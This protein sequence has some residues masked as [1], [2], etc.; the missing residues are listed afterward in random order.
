[1][2]MMPVLQTCTLPDNI[3]MFSEKS[4]MVNY[5]LNVAP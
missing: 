3:F 1:M 4:E 2:P 5:K